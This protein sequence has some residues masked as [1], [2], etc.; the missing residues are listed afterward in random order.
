[1]AEQDAVL[2][3]PGAMPEEVKAVA[4]RLEDIFHSLTAM[5]DLCNE[6]IGNPPED[7]VPTFVI[8]RELLRS[9]AMDM[10]T[11]FETL[12]NSPVKSGFFEGHF[13]KI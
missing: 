2:H 6:R 10:E 11:C 4:T 3:R 5:Y 12:Q 8:I 13:G 1:M 9:A 7:S